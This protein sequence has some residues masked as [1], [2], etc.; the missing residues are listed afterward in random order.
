[1]HGVAHG[2]FYPSLAALSMGRVSSSARGEALT[3]IY[4]A[5]NVGAS[6]ASFGFAR[7]GEAYGPAAVFPLAAG[8][9]LCGLAVLMTGRRVPLRVSLAPQPA[10]K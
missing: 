9:G 8:F 4:A 1:V 6:L 3:A 5:F 2:V 7:F 10:S